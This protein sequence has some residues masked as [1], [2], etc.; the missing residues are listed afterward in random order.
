G[1]GA[2]AAPAAADAAAS[3]VPLSTSASDASATMAPSMRKGN[4]SHPGRR[5]RRPPVRLPPGARRPDAG[6]VAAARTVDAAVPVRVQVRARPTGPGSLQVSVLPYC[7]IKVD[8]R[9]FG[10]S[11]MPQALPVPA[12]W[13]NVTCRHPV[14]GQTFARRVQVLSGELTQLRGTLL[15][16]TRVTV[17]LTRGTRIVIGA[18][19]YHPGAASL[20]PGSHRYRLLQGTTVLQTGWLR[21]PPGRCTL[22]DTPQ[23]ACR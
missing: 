8:G 6:V 11:P 3:G 22:V 14:T 10:R 17:R 19:T 15:S 23:P 1:A 7:D 4:G 20:P 21:I 13:R 18:A 5:R 12:G 2:G 16:N 9:P